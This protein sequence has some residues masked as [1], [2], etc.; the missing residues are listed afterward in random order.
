MKTFIYVLSLALLGGCYSREPEKTG[1]EGK[2]FPAFSLLLADSTSYF[3]T[4]DIPSGKASALFYFGPQCP[5]SRVQMKE[6][7]EDMDRL[8][9][10]HFYLVT[11]ASLPA[12]KKFY[13]DYKLDQ[14]PNVSI[15][16]DTGRF[17]ADYFEVP[18]VPYMAIY[19]KDKKLKK[20]YLG[21]VYTRQILDAAKE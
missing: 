16:R 21:K 14:F 9:D 3:N 13:Q 11:S 12:M 5:Y 19:G 4:G 20:S 17:V 18:G 8:K 2:P 6:I 10:I 7:V 1:L 15:G